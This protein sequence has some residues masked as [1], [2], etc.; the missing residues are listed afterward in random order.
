[1]L[2]QDTIAALAREVSPI[3]RPWTRRPSAISSATQARWIA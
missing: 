1:M 3:L 2:P